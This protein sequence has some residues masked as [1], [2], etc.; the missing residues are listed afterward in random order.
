MSNPT[1]RKRGRK[2]PALE[3]LQSKTAIAAIAIV[4]IL[5]FVGAIVAFL[6]PLTDGQPA[7]A[8]SMADARPSSFSEAAGPSETGRSRL[9]ASA[10][11]GSAPVV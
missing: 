5:G 6:D 9:E 11:L 3:R 7:P 4:I 1:H 10:S 2:K 8:L